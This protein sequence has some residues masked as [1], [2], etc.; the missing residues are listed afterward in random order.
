MNSDNPSAPA[1]VYAI[2][3]NKT[4]LKKEHVKVQQLAERLVK[5]SPAA[6]NDL[7]L[8]ENIVLQIDIARN[9]KAGAY[10]RQLKHIAN[11]LI[12]L[13]DEAFNFLHDEEN[14]LTIAAT[15]K[16]KVVEDTCIKL[17]LE[18]DDYLNQLLQK[19]PHLDRQTL[20]NLMLQARRSKEK[21][22]P[23]KSTQKLKDFLRQQTIN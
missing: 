22:V 1:K 23:D 18:G 12:D 19:S 21:Q 7:P 16:S 20:R 3:P 4:A 6:L 11:L 13:D 15:Q 9:I 10:R 5:K 2:R 17:I 14:Q 8:N